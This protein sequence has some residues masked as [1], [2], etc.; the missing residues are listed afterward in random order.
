MNLLTLTG[1]LG[2]DCE[3]KQV[4]TSTVCSFS[5]AMKAGFGDKAQT[6]WLDCAIWGKKAEGGLPAYLKKGQQV[7]VSGELSTFDATNGKTYLKLRCNNVDL[8]GGK[9]E[10]VQQAPAPQMRQPAPAP[11]W[12]DPDPV[13][14]FSDDIPF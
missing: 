13:D 7:A 1:N 8:I 10:G 12:P 4:G 14:D 2:Q 11:G 3:V 9:S 6:V 5:V